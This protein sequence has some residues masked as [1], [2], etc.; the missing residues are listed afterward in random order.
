[1]TSFASPS[2]PGPSPSRANPFAR[3]TASHSPRSFKRTSLLPSLASPA[4]VSKHLTTPGDKPT[5][6]ANTTYG[7][8][9]KAR[10][11]WR[12]LWRGGLEIGK[13]GWR[14]DGELGSCTCT[15]RSPDHPQASLS[16]QNYH[17]LLRH[18][19]TKRPTPLT[20]RNKAPH[21]SRPLHRSPAFRLETLTSASRSRVC[22]EGSIS[23]SEAWS[24]SPPKRFSKGPTRLVCKCEE[25]RSTVTDAQ[26][27]RTKRPVARW[28]L[29]GV[30]V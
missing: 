14:L 18:P 22:G 4:K 29:Y 30:V 3:P 16:S 5:A 12:L 28:L 13:D 10:Q 6:G 27:D 19:L 20:R 17:F 23:N 26:V 2:L 1:M 24:T 21:R 8:G 25:Q 11:G 9:S 7:S 15:P